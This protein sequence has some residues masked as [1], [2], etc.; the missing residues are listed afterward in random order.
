VLV[1]DPSERFNLDAAFGTLWPDAAALCLPGV[2]ATLASTP[3]AADA[4]VLR[5][6]GGRLVQDR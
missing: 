1:D 3:A 2:N 4:L 6:A 5:L